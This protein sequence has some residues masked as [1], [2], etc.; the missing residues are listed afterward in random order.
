MN[1]EMVCDAAISFLKIIL[2]ALFVNQ[3]VDDASE[4]TN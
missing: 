2:W 3:I 4:L 1:V